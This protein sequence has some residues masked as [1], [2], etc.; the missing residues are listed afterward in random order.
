MAEMITKMPSPNPRRALNLGITPKKFTNNFIVC[1]EK[2]GWKGLIKA[3][4]GISQNIIFGGNA[5]NFGITP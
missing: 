5:K 3:N 2:N 4:C 1:G